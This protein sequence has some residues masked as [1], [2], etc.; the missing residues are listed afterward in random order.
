MN[1]LLRP[2]WWISMIVSTFVTMI[3]IYLIKKASQKIN[4]PIVSDIV[5]SV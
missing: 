3:F 5:E 2:S 4:V 1:F